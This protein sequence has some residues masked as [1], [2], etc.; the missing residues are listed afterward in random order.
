MTKVSR[1]DFLKFAG[2]MFSGLLISEKLLEIEKI[3]SPQPNIIILLCDAFSARHL[4]LYGYPR[5]TTPNIDAFAERSYVFHQHYSGGNFTTTGTASM[6][7]GMLPWKHRAIN[8]GGLVRSEFVGSN[9]YTLLGP[10]YYRLAFSQNPWPDRLMGQYYKDIDRF[11]LPSSFSLLAA[12]SQARFLNND[13]ALAS[14]AIEDFLLPAQKYELTG[15]LLLGYINKSRNLNLATEISSARYPKGFPEIMDP[16]YLIPYLNEEVYEGVLSELSA[17]EAKRSPY[18]AYFHLYSPH[19]PYRPRKDYRNMFEDGY[20]PQPKPIHPLSS[21]LHESYTLS[22]RDLY[23]RH[24]AQVD[25][26][27]GRLISRLDE[28]GALDNSNLIFT[29]DH[30]ELFERGFVGHGFQ[31]MYEPVLR[32]PLIIRAP[33]QTQRNDIFTPT[34]NIDLLPTLLSIAGKEIPVDMDGQILPGFGGVIEKSR[35]IIS[36][37]ATENSAFVRLKKA[38][39]SMRKDAYKLIAYLGYNE[40]DQSFELYDLENDPEELENLTNKE[41]NRLSQMKDELLGYLDEANRPFVTS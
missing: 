40:L 21:A 7:T 17:L 15:S 20:H 11:L 14:V 28:I 18:F 33:G 13:H 8:Y 3:N 34:S 1:R 27:F 41:K 6:L 39:I 37:V 38:V 31:F 36:L 5:L 26:E 25:A 29:S 23:D 32:I 9:P 19:Y 10:D 30:G 4:S 24:V 16:G 12:A 2:T 35:P 22:Q